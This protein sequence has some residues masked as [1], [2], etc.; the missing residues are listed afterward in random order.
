MQRRLVFSIVTLRRGRRGRTLEPRR[1][2]PRTEPIRPSPALVRV[3]VD[4]PTG[5][6]VVDSVEV[7]VVPSQ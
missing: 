4:S 1:F 7:L 3:V 5:L 2:V 6:A